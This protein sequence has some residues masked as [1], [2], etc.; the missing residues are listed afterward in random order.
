MTF[1]IAGSAEFHALHWEAM[2]DLELPCAFALEGPMVR[3]NLTP[4]PVDAELRPSPTINI[5]VVT[6]RPGGERDVGYRTISRPL[7]EGLRP[8]Q[9][10]ATD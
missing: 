1:E 4:H 5:L 10:K 6:A 7:V 8:G 9:A 3:K 2:K